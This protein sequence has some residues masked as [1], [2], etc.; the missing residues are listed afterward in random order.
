[1][2]MLDYN[3]QNFDPEF[4][5]Y[6]WELLNTMDNTRIYNYD[7]LEKNFP[8]FKK[9]MSRS[10]FNKPIKFMLHREPHELVM[11]L[12]YVLG[13]AVFW[14]EDGK[15]EVIK[16]GY[17]FPWTVNFKPGGIQDDYFP[18]DEGSWSF[19]TATQKTTNTIE[20]FFEEE[21][22]KNISIGEDIFLDEDDFLYQLFNGCRGVY[23]R[24]PDK[25]EFYKELTTPKYKLEIIS[26]S[27]EDY[28]IACTP[29]YYTYKIVHF[30]R[31]IKVIYFIVIR[32]VIRKH[33]KRKEPD[34][35]I[36]D[37]E[38]ITTSDDNYVYY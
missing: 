12:D 7:F 20:D 28:I 30:T 15:G 18:D 23:A 24:S 16:T 6:I 31:N 36:Y 37:N 11:K 4:L 32:V 26:Q 9:I 2:Y 13:S 27:D 22:K 1:M 5:W 33:G 38:E 3:I 14:Y 25:F 34:S 29:E 17:P 19:Y 35:I 21:A 10:Q 8:D